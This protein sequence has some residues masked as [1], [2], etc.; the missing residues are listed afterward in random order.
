VRHDQPRHANRRIERLV[1][2]FLPLGIACSGEI[3]PLGRANVVHENV[4]DPEPLDRRPDDLLRPFL[5]GKIRG[6]A[7]HRRPRGKSSKLL[8]GF[9]ERA[10]TPRANADIAA[11]GGERPGAGQ[12]EAPAGASHD[13]HFA[14]ELEIH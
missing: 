4:D 11:F 13:G 12:A 7:D 9:L 1:Q 5:G 10:S 6:D 2:R 3:A 14:V 8:T